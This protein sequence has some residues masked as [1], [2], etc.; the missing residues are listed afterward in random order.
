MEA[1][2][3]FGISWPAFLSQLL[4]LIITLLAIRHAW[5]HESGYGF[6]FW[7]IFILAIPIIGSLAAFMC[8]PTTKSWSETYGQK[9]KANKPRH[10]SPDRAESK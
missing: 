10:S 6:L 1:I 8:L 2:K 7:L 5:K 9:R 3:E 4:L